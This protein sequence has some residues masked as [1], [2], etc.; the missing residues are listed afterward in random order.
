M[1]SVVFLNGEYLPRD[2]ARLPVDERGFLFGDGIY[3][4]TRA[5]HGRLFEPV[6]HMRRLHAGLAGLSITG[7]PAIDDLIA[8]H[9]RLLAENGLVD[10]DALVYTQITRGVAPR[11][12]RFPVPAVPPTVFLS[13]MPFAPNLEVRERGTRAV[14]YP[15]IRW[16][17][18]DLKTVN[19]LGNVL[20]NQHA[21]ASGVTES[22][23]VRDAAITEGSHTNVFGVIA[24]EL[25]TYPR[26]HYIL[27]GITRDVMLELAAE[28]GIPVR[29][30]PILAHEIPMLE[31]LFLT[32]T[33]TDVTPIIELDG[34][35]V[36][37]GAVG[38]IA[39]MLYRALMERVMGVGSGT[40]EPG[41]ERS[42]AG[43][44]R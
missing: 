2:Q 29:E 25:R 4:M 5:W 40:R 1:T 19:L 32:G 38:P 13:A 42:A 14:T 41:L 11:T 12:H 36:G 10:R 43:A 17:R 8:I 22:I 27:G 26:S 20:A 3:E 24:G 31:E 37:T 35:P 34:R 9:Q 18:C 16:A 28:R 33:T 15:D 39:A 30:T 21:A 7:A 44:M 23:F 6:G